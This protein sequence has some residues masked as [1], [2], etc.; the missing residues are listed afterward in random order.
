MPGFSVFDSVPQSIT[1]RALA[2]NFNLE[3]RTRREQ[4]SLNKDFYYGKQEQALVLMSD[5]QEPVV[6]NLIKPIM[7]KRCNMVYS[8]PLVREFDGNSSSI[9]A[10]QQVYKDNNIDTLL[11]TADLMAELTGSC[12]VHPTPDPELPGKVRL[13]LY[14]GSQ[15]SA[16]GQDND[17]TTADA[18]SLIRLVDHLQNPILVGDKSEPNVERILQQQV[19]T[20]DQVILYSGSTEERIEP[21]D[22]GFLPF[23]NFRGEEVHDQYVGFAPATIIRKLNN[24]INTFLSHVGYM[25]KMQAGTP[26]IFQGFKNGESIIV[27]P[28]RAINIPTDASASTLALN[29]KITDTLAAIQ[30][31]EDRIYTT[32]G[33]PKIS[34][35]GGQGV[36]GKELLIRWFPLIQVF[37]EK[38]VRFSKYEL[39]LANMILTILGMDPLDD[40]NPL[41]PE[42]SILPYDVEDDTLERDIALDIRTPVDEILKRNPELSYGEAMADWHANQQVNQ[43][44]NIQNQQGVPPNGPQ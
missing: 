26:I 33:V 23:V 42:E 13:V 12:L 31:L 27:H 39:E 37:R 20:K 29:P 24:H 14:D 43:V 38:T 41:W 3:E 40:V 30:F 4:A 32:S 17:P 9:K 16:V 25:I 6:L 5:E 19:W 1:A 22:L 44:L 35:E 21:N 18:V 8:R 28:G 36:S 34:V 2:Q 15:F 10:L 11:K 7:V